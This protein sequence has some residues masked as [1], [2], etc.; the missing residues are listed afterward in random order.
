MRCEARL[1]CHQDLVSSRPFLD[2]GLHEEL[3][4]DL[5]KA[6]HLPDEFLAYHEALLMTFLPPRVWEVNEHAHD[7][8]LGI[9]PLERESGVLREDACPSP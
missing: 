7:R 9:E 5:E 2:V 6:C 4:P 8:A 1:G 3:T